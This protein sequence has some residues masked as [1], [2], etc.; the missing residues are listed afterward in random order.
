MKTKLIFCLVVFFGSLVSLPF[1][2][3]KEKRDAYGNKIDAVYNV[4]YEYNVYHNGDKTDTVQVD[5]IYKQIN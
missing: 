3:R 1:V 5:I 2:I 4:Y